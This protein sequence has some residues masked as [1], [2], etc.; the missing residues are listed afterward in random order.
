MTGQEFWK[1][2]R[3]DDAIEAQTAQVKTH[4]SD[5]ESRYLLFAFLCFAGNL[6]RADKQLDAL[7][8]QDTKLEAG[9][10]IYRNLLASEAERRRVW[11]DGASP[12]MPPDAPSWMQTRLEAIRASAAGDAGAAESAIAAARAGERTMSGKADGRRFEAI[13]DIDDFLEPVL[14]AFAGGRYL[15]IPFERIRSLELTEPKHLLDLLWATAKLTDA[16]G[17]IADVHLP[18][19]YV[20]S[21]Q[22]PS[23]ALRLGRA[24]DWPDAPGGCRGRGQKVLFLAAPQ[25]KPDPEPDDAEVSLLSLRS[26]EIGGAAASAAGDESEA[27]G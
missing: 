7:G 20:D 3:L 18:A 1:A 6:E 13:L 21:P 14:E 17:T 10:M 11:R 26:L 9:S 15:W 12:L 25:G 16:D 24:T 19:L 27:E 22:G 5:P 8:V 4:P 23:D 2:G